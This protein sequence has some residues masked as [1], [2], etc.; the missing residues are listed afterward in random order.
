[1]AETTQRKTKTAVITGG[2]DYDVV[3]FQR[4]FRGIP[5]IDFYPQN[6]WDYAADHSQKEYEVLLF[7]NMHTVTPGTDP[8]DRWGAAERKAI[9][10]LGDTS[11]GIFLL[12]HALVAY[13]EWPLWGE[14]SGVPRRSG[15]Q[16]FTMQ[17]VRAD[18]TDPDHPIT[19]GLESFEVV[20]ET[21]IED[22][23]G[24]GS[25]VLLTTDHPRSMRTIAWTRQHKNARV[26]CYQ[27]GHDDVAFSTPGFRTVVTRGIQWC[28]G[29]I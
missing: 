16:G 13:P 21:Y 8:G 25:T 23:A 17:T 3:S 15:V 20:D 7:Y 27:S 22:D 24:E 2:H 11:Q 9:E 14:I 10:D 18:I 6:L 28:A 12:H 19:R 29:R 1:M 5:E 4:L 26:F